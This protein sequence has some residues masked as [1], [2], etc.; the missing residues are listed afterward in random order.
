MRLQRGLMPIAVVMVLACAESPA[1]EP[2]TVTLQRA[3]GAA[4][5]NAVQASTTGGGHYLLQ[6]L[7]DAT[8]SFGASQKGD[9]DANGH[10]RLFVDFGGADGTADFDG[11]VTCMTSDPIHGRAWVGGVVTS[12][13]STSADF[14]T[15]IHQPGRDVWFRVLDSGEGS[16]PNGDRTSLFG[17]TGAAGF[18]TSADY[19][20]GQ[21]WPDA[22]ARTHPVTS[23]NIQVR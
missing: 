20:A 21:P 18:Q 19:C 8:F 5:A 4:S 9:G 2:T 6:G 10:F 16:P 7:Y 15:A 23:G 14:Q 17:F 11:T 3:P 22:N 13:N 12:N 1:T